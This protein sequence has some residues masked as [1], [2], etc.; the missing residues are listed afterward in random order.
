MKL[1]RL[2]PLSFLSKQPHMLDDKKYDML[3]SRVYEII[4]G[5]G[6]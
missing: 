6:S 4:I 5:M 1:K 2:F 3:S